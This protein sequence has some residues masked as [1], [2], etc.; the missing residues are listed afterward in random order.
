[1]KRD[2]FDKLTELEYPVTRVRSAPSARVAQELTWL[3]V[4]QPFPASWRCFG[5]IVLMLCSPVLLVLLTLLNGK[6]T[7]QQE[8]RT[9]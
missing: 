2:T 8:G 1:M 7:R 3:A 6:F 4:L 9:S 5:P